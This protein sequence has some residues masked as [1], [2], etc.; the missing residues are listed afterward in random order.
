MSTYYKLRIDT[1]NVGGV[2]T[3]LKRYCEIYLTSIEMEG[4]EDVH[5]HS[6]IETST[7]E[8]TIRNAVRKAYGSGNGVY[9]LKELSESRPVEY[10]A[11][12]IKGRQYSTN[13]PPDVVKL[14]EDYD[15]VVKK[16]MK[17][18]KLLRKSVFI[19]LCEIIDERPESLKSMELKS[20]FTR[21]VLDYYKSKQLAVRTFQL[22]SLVQTLLLKYS[23]EYY[24]QLADKVIELL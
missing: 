14:A 22:V 17:E 5:T 11:Y 4:T 15:M 1:D 7:K 21:I 8:A 19:Q 10:L 16:G 6:Y 2:I 13:L 24:Q 18:K 23:P 20:Y 3:L 9:S 12:C